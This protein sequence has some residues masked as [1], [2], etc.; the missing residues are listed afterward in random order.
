[1]AFDFSPKT[2][3]DNGFIQFN[4]YKLQNEDK[5]KVTA[6]F[7]VSQNPG[8]VIEHLDIASEFYVHNS[9]DG[10]GTQCGE[11]NGSFS[12]VGYYHETLSSE[13]V[14]VNSCEKTIRQTHRLSVGPCCNNFDG[15]D[16]FPYEYRNWATLHQVKVQIPV[17]YNYVSAKFRQW[18]TE[19][20]NSSKMQT[21]NVEPI[22]IVNNELVFDL[23]ATYNANGGIMIPS[24]GGFKSRL[25]VKV[26]PE[27]SIEEGVKEPVYWDF[28][29]S[30][31]IA[32]GGNILHLIPDQPDYVRHTR[33]ELQVSADAVAQEAT[34]LTTD[35][36]I[37]V[38]AKSAAAKNAWL[39]LDYDTSEMIITDVIDRATGTA[40]T[41]S[42]DLFII[43]DFNRN[44]RKAYRI[45]A[46]YI[47]CDQSE[48][49]V[50]TGYD[51]NGYPASYADNI[52]T[53]ASTTLSIIPQPAEL[54]VKLEIGAL[55]GVSC[56]DTLSV[57]LEMLSTKMSS[58]ADLMI[59]IQ[60]A[61]SIELIPGSCQVQYPIGAD[62]SPISDP[63]MIDGSLTLYAED[64]HPDL[65]TNGLLGVT[66]L[67]ANRIRMRFNI[68]LDE[69]FQQGDDIDIIVS[70][71]EPCGD[72][73]PDMAIKVD[74]TNSFELLK[75]I[76]LD[77]LANDWGMAWSDYNGDGFV[78][79]FVTNYDVD[80][81]NR[82]YRNNGNGTFTQD[83]IEP[84]ISDMAL[85]LAATW[86]DYDNDGDI[87]L[88][89]T[90]NIGSKN[91]LYR[92]N[93]DG[94]FTKVLNDPMV[95]YDGYSHG[96]AWGDY[97][98]D[99]YLDMFV[100]DYF[101]TRFNKLYRN[102]GDGTFSE[103]PSAVP[104]L[105]NSSSVGAVWG[106]Y[107]NDGKID[108]FVANINNENNSLYRNQG[109]GMFEKIT[110]GSVV[111]DGG[112][113]TGA[114][115]GDMDN[116]GDLDLFV[117]NAG[118]QDNFLYRNN[119]NG[120]FTKV[121][122]DPV[123]MDSGHSHGSAW[124]DFDNDG[125]LDLTVGNDAGGVNHMYINDGTG[126]FTRA[127]NKITQMTNNS[128]GLG[129]A[130]IDNDL[131]LDLY[132]VN[133]S[134]QANSM[135]Q[136]NKG[137][138]QNTA[139]IILNGT[140]SNFCGIGAKIFVK[141]TIDGKSVSQ[142]REVSSQSG[143]GIGG[144]NEMRT[145]FGLGDASIID[146]IR[147]EW[148][149]GYTQHLTNVPVNDC[150]IIE[151]DQGGEIC[152][153]VYIDGNGNCIQDE[154]EAGIPNQKVLIEPGGYILS[155]DETG[156][157]QVFVEPGSYDI[158]QEESSLWNQTCT[159]DYSVEVGSFDQ[160]YC[161]NDFALIPVERAV[162]LIIE[163]TTTPHR[164][165][166]ENLIAITYLNVGTIVAKDIQLE[167]VVGDGMD[168]LEASIPWD[169]NRSETAI[170]TTLDSL[171]I[172]ASNTIFV[173]NQ[174]DPNLAVGTL[175][176]M[177]A[178]ITSSN[179]EFV[180]S[181]N[182]T[183][184]AEPAV[185]AFDPN[186]ILVS[187]E[188]Y[189]SSDQEL[190]YTIRFQNVGNAAASTVRIEDQLP[191]ELDISTFKMGIASHAYRLEIEEDNRLVWHF[192]NI[193]IPD[194]TSNE[195]ESH[196]HVVFKIKPKPNQE[197]GANIHNSAL[198]YFDNNPSIHTNVVIN[199]IG[200]PP[201]ERPIET[202]IEETMN[203]FPN[204]T[205]GS[206]TVE[207]I[208]ENGIRIN[209][210]SVRF[211]SITGQKLLDRKGLNVDHFIIDRR[212]F[213]RGYYIVR[214]LDVNGKEYVSKLNMQ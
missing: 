43:N 179:V 96:A 87:D 46:T 120:S 150:L 93:G 44:A 106:D 74:P 135:F 78:D 204:P 82:L 125:D 176:P 162:D 191:S 197:D 184:N 154:G 33:A 101:T 56:T 142:M 188:G 71:A 144:Q 186:D 123:V 111:N 173:K 207:I 208:D 128:F 189:I 7:K 65:A 27:C 2:L 159:L 62:Y 80:Q 156:T 121:T 187:P 48:F 122:D 4:N 130:D 183:T 194:S 89:V 157:Y 94:T 116:D 69:S 148:T 109:N 199:T 153:V 18:R 192:E 177:S 212:S 195:V 103:I 134:E 90:N 193:N 200:S 214:A 108:L 160:T 39:Y 49:N 152:G 203:V 85:S 136:N 166:F 141:A 171:G 34:N 180:T 158:E 14:N 64:L 124:V 84:F 25:D 209:L 30:E 42:G 105:E 83:L 9:E 12:V 143:G 147:I 54:Q 24:D 118:N 32:L 174:I 202:E 113:S 73:L 172:G 102:N 26:A 201:E 95:N 110:T 182:S 5:V 100:A 31:S 167:L 67:T 138:C 61:A 99:G 13:N 92:N 117:S 75:G 149:S 22:G 72:P 86:G 129:W 206:A 29:L 6:L 23:A 10:N 51:C 15:G 50:I 170:W 185:G 140:N 210:Y 213:P 126:H 119:G 211:Y 1:V 37:I 169:L 161:G 165:G 114:S 164:I 17:G 36:E 16:F 107:D 68:Q 198:I 146:S 175:I 88:F 45:S 66:D 145:L 60:K 59:Q 81:P 131:D 11:W 112:T 168:L 133:H 70:G 104:A 127:E 47:N 205:S 63:T 3:K 178:Q 97:D 19:S 8:G 21:E 53:E 20:T 41:K 79:L 151:E 77:M 190:I 181:N 115:W 91:F 76:G 137:Q 57:E 55:G 98:N 58:V 52:C 40:L 139:C 132:V 155:T 38:T 28:E 196:G 35:W 163:I